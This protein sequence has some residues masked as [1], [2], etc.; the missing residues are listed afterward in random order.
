MTEDNGY[1]FNKLIE[2]GM[3]NFVSDGQVHTDSLAIPSPFR[4]NDMGFSWKAETHNFNPSIYM[5]A[6]GHDKEA[7]A[8]DFGGT[9]VGNIDPDDA[10][11][12]FV[13]P[14]E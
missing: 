5:N 10:N 13:R 4:I 2:L 9:P 1:Y 11:F 3:T 14:G 7:Y 6:I 12:G 8:L